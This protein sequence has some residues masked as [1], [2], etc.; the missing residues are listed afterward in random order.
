VKP[1]KT[2]LSIR[3]RECRYVIDE[4]AGASTLFCGDPVE[5][6]SYCAAHSR[7]VYARKPALEPGEAEQIIRGI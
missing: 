5:R 7:I 3:D 1:Y 4:P 6:G 2:L